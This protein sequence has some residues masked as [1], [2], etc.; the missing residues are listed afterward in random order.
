MGKCA[1]ILAAIMLSLVMMKCEPAGEKVIGSRNHD[2]HSAY[3]TQPQIL[4]NGI[5]TTE[6]VANVRSKDGVAAEKMRVHFETNYGKIDEYAVT[7]NSGNARVILTSAASD[8]DIIAT[9]TAVV[10]DTTFIPLA[11]SGDAGYRVKLT[12]PGFEDQPR[13]IKGVAKA[14]QQTDN[15]ASIKVKFLG[16]DLQAVVDDSILTADGV[17]ETRLEIRLRETTSRKVIEDAEIR[18][19]MI[20]GT[21]IK[22]IKT[23]NQGMAEA[24]LKAAKKVVTDTLFISYGNEISR[25]IALK[26]LNPKFELYPRTARV[27]A[28][29]VSKVQ[30]TATLKTQQN[31]PIAGAKI[32]FSSSAGI[33]SE[34]AIT[35]NYGQ[36]IA[37]LIS[38]RRPDSLVKVFARFNSLR[39][40]AIISFG[41]IDV[42]TIRITSDEEPILRDGIATKQLTITA[43]NSLGLPVPNIAI[44]LTTNIGKIPGAVVTDQ[45][46]NASCQFYADAGSA[47]ATATITATAGSAQASHTV[48]LLGITMTVSANPAS[49]LADGKSTSTIRVELKQ[50]T[51]H[52]AVTNHAIT[53]AAN[54][55]LIPTNATSDNQGVA[56]TT[57]TGS[58]V[59]GIATISVTCGKLIG[60]T[61]VSLLANYPKTIS[62]SADSEPI[63]RDGIA[64]KSMTVTATNELGQPV[65]NVAINLQA[66]LGSVPASVIT[67]SQGKASFSYTS[68]AGSA[69]ATATV[70]AKVGSLLA[71]HTVK[72]LG[73]TMTVSANPAS[74]LADGKSTSTIR[75][76]VKQS[77]SHLAVA[78]HPIS[79]ATNNG[80]IPTTANTDQQGVANVNYT[81]SFNPGSATV[82]AKCGTMTQT[83]QITLLANYPKTISLSADSEPILRD[84]IATKSI[85]VTAT[86]EL[87]QPVP[88]VLITLQAS[89]GAVPGSVITDSQGKASFSYTSD[90]G[91]ADATAT[92][93]ATA[94]SAQASHTV[95]LLG[96]TMTVS[97]NPASILADGKS[98]STIRV[99][100][101]QT[102]SHVAVTNHAITFAANV[103]LIP[104]NATS[105]NQ[106]VATTTYTGS[107][108]P[109]IATISVT[110]GK[111][112]GET[113]VS[114]LANYPKTISLSADSEPILRDGIAT[115]SMTVTATNELGQPVPNVAINLQANLGSVPASVI[116]DSQGK[117]SFSYTSDAGSADA[118]A[119]VT[120]TVGSL[121]AS[122][123]VKLLGIT[124]TVSAN[125][126]SI[127]ADGKST[128][129]IRVELKQT[130]SQLAIGNYS[131]RFA[132]DYGTIPATGT[133]D[134]RGVANATY[135]SSTKVGWANITVTAGQLNQKIGVYLFGNYPNS[136]VLAVDQNF[137]SVR[138]TGGIQQAIIT[139]TILGVT[140]QPVGNDYGVRFRI[141]SGPGGGEQIEPAGASS[142]ETSVIR[143]VNGVAQAKLL[144]GNVSGTVQVR[145]E[146]VDYPYISAQTTNIVIRSGPAYMWVDSTNI[147]HV[148]PHATLTVEPGKFN[149]NFGNPVHEIKVTVYFAD[150]YNNPVENGTVVYFTTTGGMITTNAMINEQGKATVLLQDVNPFPYLKSSDPNQ[151]TAM[152]IPN[153]NNEIY[154]DTL[155]LNT[156]IPDFE[157][158]RVYNT[159]GTL[160]END[161]VA[162]ILAYTWG[163]DQN[164]K[165]IKVW[166]MNKV[167]YSVGLLEFTATTD[168]SVLAPNQSATITIRVYD[169]HGNPVAAGSKLTVSTDAG[170]LSETS[171]MPSAEK[172]GWGT[173]KFQV[174]LTN[175][176]KSTDEPKT[177]H[178]KIELDSTNGDGKLT[179]NIDLK[180]T[181]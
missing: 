149:V 35:D 13:K 50:T 19:L 180:N 90:A 109:G 31:T 34:S 163:K 77:T 11:K 116:T 67:D 42:S 118:T 66:N 8:T 23:D 63:L 55:G 172:Y 9:V 160:K 174:T 17:S 132:V 46:G 114:L 81:S 130:T 14:E 101:K 146:L 175:N 151:L 72:L 104:T 156:D 20:Y 43:K 113:K 16:V 111:L 53:F 106:G 2:I 154:N 147:N 119:T 59:P 152:N 120:A 3:A 129:L 7:D 65:P 164:G 75:V 38:D 134:S 48:K 21:I 6:I 79:F 10:M 91:S 49:I 94:G 73:I 112:I 121:L 137:I 159:L 1:Q 167:V 78:N 58:N 110:C 33:I 56:T 64:T 15:R 148:I 166:A 4:A 136:I 36:A 105:D 69:D 179:L 68:D 26:Y 131:L 87:G 22:S 177:A 165:D 173:T 98:T 108:V 76:E 52:V 128:S 139:A 70:T 47:D 88:N 123:T 80:T 83:V 25:K 51:S 41:D 124:M 39:D 84:G 96:I 62:L 153:P 82:S 122:H 162:V 5:A 144:A 57:Y 30:M 32:R 93:T 102:T 178:V 150:K 18:L 40:S 85:T 74:I 107:N 145:A 37:N 45:S 60:E 143:T 127:A 115:K 161:G 135:Q 125:P 171:L 86:N 126:D 142:S 61:K 140:G 97:A 103:G 12:V 27:P 181:P 133:T 28:D 92:I 168:R 170:E 95:K 54:V 89:L 157:I 44:N 117:A 141:V 24:Y 155:K 29:G 100:L 169:R 71:S 158:S 176:L 99:E 138:G